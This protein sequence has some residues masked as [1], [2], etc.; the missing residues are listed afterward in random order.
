[1]IKQERCLASAV[2]R[3]GHVLHYA[4]ARQPASLLPAAPVSQVLAVPQIDPA[5]RSAPADPLALSARSAL[6]GLSAPV[7]QSSHVVVFPPEVQLSSVKDTLNKV[8][9]VSQGSLQT[10]SG[11]YSPLQTRDRRTRR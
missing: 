8:S 7:Y 9:K 5:I 6:V 1:M 3:C 2:N 4:S 11:C 10:I